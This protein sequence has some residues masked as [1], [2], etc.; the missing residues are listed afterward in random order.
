MQ[1]D[2]AP[3]FSEAELPLAD[4]LLAARALRLGVAPGD[5]L[6]P[7]LRDIAFD[8]A[9]RPDELSEAYVAAAEAR[10]AAAAK[11][12]ETKATESVNEGATA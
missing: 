6:R 1:I 2:T 4:R 10:A 5:I 11:A 3:A 7:A 12:R 8:E 9:G